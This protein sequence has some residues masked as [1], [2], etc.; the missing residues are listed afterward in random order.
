[1]R[2]DFAGHPV[3]IVL[4]FC[5]LS[6]PHPVCVVTGTYAHKV[7][8]PNARCRLL[9]PGQLATSNRNAGSSDNRSE[10]SSRS[11]CWPAP[12]IKVSIA[13]CGL[14]RAL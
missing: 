5:I 10:T 3:A 8:L 4:F 6:A 7:L 13:S 2:P 9:S 11:H 1:M 12:R 14:R